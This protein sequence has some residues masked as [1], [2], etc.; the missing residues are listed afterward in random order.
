MSN[1]NFGFQDPIEV[2]SSSVSSEV[3]SKTFMSRVFSWM[4]IGLAI[5]GFMGYIF[6]ATGL[7]TVI[8][9]AGHPTPVFYICMFAPFALVL[10]MGMGM[11]R[12][13]YP[14]MVGVFVLYSALTGMGLM[15]AM[16]IIYQ[17]SSVYSVFF[18]TA[19]LFG[20]MAFLGWT[21]NTDLTKF[22]SLL[23]MLLIG[24]MIAALVNMFMGSAPMGY[25]ISFIFVA[26]FTGLTA[27]DVQ[28][29]KNIGAQI[30]SSGDAS[31][32]KMAIWGAL[33]LYLDF[34]NLFL[35]L[36]RIFGNRR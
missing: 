34:I 6:S 26:V 7:S 32:G 20:V 10:L 14:A 25:A 29:L 8:F 30:G 2:H 9:S 12:L 13:S 36:L 1:Q 3:A 18:I 31:V 4:F 22:G 11:N 16:F 5:T 28:K 21:T 15:S 23:V 33:S 24:A 19:G 35:A 17:A 27:Y